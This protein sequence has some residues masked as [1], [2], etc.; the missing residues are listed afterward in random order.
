M[1]HRD[2]V[3]VGGGHNALVC[4]GY[5]AAAGLSVTVL[6]R[7]PRLGG[8]A[9]KVEFLPGYWTTASNSPGSLE[10]KIARD[11]ELERFG[12]KFLTQDPTLVHPLEDG[13]LFVGWRD[14]ERTAAQ[15]EAFAPGEAARYDALF[16][17][18]QDFA[19]KLGVSVFRPPPSLQE[20]TRNLTSLADQEAFSRLF[21]G[22]VRDLLEEFELAAETKAVIGPLATVGG[23]GAPGTPGTP[24][25]LLMRPLSLASLA[26][27]SRLRP[28]PHAAARLDRPPRGRHGCHRRGDGGERPKPR[29]RDAQGHRGGAHPDARQRRARRRAP[30]RARSTE[31]SIVVAACHP[32]M[33]VLD[34]VKDG[35]EGWGELQA[36][37]ARKRFQGKT[38][39]LV[40][41]LDGM[42]RWERAR[43]KRNRR[44]SPARSSASRRRSTISRR[45]MTDMLLGRVPEKPVIWGLCPSLGAPNLA[46]DGK[47]LLS[48]N[49]GTAP[50]HLRGATGRRS[51][52]AG[53]RGAAS[54]RCRGLDADL[55]DLINDWRASTRPSS[56]ATGAS[57]RRTWRMATCRRGTSFCMRPLPGLHDYRTPTRG[58]YL[59]GVGTWP[60]NYVSGI[61]GHNASQA[62]LEDLRQRRLE[63]AGRTTVPVGS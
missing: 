41:A 21:F 46:P 10:P 30:V 58:L 12:L 62:I 19:D 2:V 13:R 17:Y 54:R 34:L 6:E 33:T 8:P 51:A 9:A 56:S 53:S 47:H 32:R 20:L 14:K 63:I 35:A 5:L 43:A 44:P 28:A 26:A 37:M 1:P 24:M 31:A 4:A 57:S 61:P 29:R 59:S 55:P 16:K 3:I 7:S 60:G 27:D 25:N 40:L 38:F 52:T 50:Y 45:R 42:P 15:L 22:S 11:L 23:F 49:V 18:I 48:L 36:K 39:K